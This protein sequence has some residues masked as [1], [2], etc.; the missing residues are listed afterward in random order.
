M[1]T[2]DELLREQVVGAWRPRGRDGGVKVHPAWHDLPAEER[3]RAF[4]EAASARRLEA[5]I[6]AQGLSSTTKAVLARINRNAG[7]P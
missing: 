5:A 2:S 3:E 1:A 6:D 7:F 4:D